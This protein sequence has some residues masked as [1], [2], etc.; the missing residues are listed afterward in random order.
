MSGTLGQYHLKIT[1]TQPNPDAATF[2]LSGT[3][4]AFKMHGT[5]TEGVGA[6]GL[7]F[8]ERGAVGNKALTASGA[9]SVSSTGSYEVTFSGH[10][11]ATAI[12][13]KIPL[14]ATT[15]A[16]SVSGFVKVS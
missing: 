11:G 15:T 8:K 14:S 9:F 6:D 10:L 3:V 7:T 1:I 16:R 13:A 5:L 12:S 2:L 4:G